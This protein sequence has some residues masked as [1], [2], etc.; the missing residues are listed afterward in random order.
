MSIAT[1]RLLIADR[2]KAAT[3]EVVGEGDGVNRYFQLDMYP[4]ASAPTATLVLLNTGVT[5]ATNTYTISGGVGRITLTA[6][7]T[8]GNTLLANYKYVALTDSEIT[9]ILSGHT[10]EPYLA[11]ANAALVLAADASRLFAYTMGDKSVDKR[12]VASNLIELSKELE[13]RHYRIRD[14]TNF[15]GTVFTF[16]DASN[17]YYDGYDTSIAYVTGTD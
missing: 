11:A 14:D 16:K 5:A 15:D 3:N 9:D 2:V 4:L 7:L 17:T 1:V 12:K 13:N 10:G 8:A 6:F